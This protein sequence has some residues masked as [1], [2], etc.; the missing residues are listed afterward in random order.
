MDKVPFN[1]LKVLFQAFRCFFIFVFEHELLVHGRYMYVFEKWAGNCLALL[2]MK[3]LTNAMKGKLDLIFIMFCYCCCRRTPIANTFAHGKRKSNN[4]MFV[5]ELNV[6]HA[7]FVDAMTYGFASNVDCESV[8][9][10]LF[11]YVLEEGIMYL[12]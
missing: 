4:S 6:F 7:C 12:I 11:A 1:V 9:L 8:V 3:L 2:P 5:C 10:P